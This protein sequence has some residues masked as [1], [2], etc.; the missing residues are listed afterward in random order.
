MTAMA[1]SAR[2]YHN[3]GLPCPYDCAACDR[4]WLPDP[5]PEVLWFAETSSGARLSEDLTFAEV[6]AFARSYA[7]VVGQTVR[8]RRA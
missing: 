8:I 1:D 5:D 2:E 6:K 3:Q 7:S 4:S